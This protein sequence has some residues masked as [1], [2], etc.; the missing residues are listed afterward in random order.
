MLC[1]HLNDL[2]CVTDMIEEH[3]NK[4]SVNLENHGATQRCNKVR[5]TYFF[6]ASHLCIDLY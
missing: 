1:E 5:S 6:I 4:L 3:Y 2:L